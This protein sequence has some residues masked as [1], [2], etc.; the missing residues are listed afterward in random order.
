VS[1]PTGTEALLEQESPPGV[2]GALWGLYYAIY[3]GTKE[4]VTSLPDPVLN[5]YMRVQKTAG[6]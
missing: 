6:F 5:A 1:E 2:V 3:Y 4:A